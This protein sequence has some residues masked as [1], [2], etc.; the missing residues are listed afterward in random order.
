[1]IEPVEIPSS[2]SANIADASSQPTS[3]R[4]TVNNHEDGW[5]WPVIGLITRA[6][7]IS[8]ILF[9]FICVHSRFSL[10]PQHDSPP[11]EFGV[12]EINQQA[13]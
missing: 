2:E 12:L 7:P 5:N 3:K 4:I 10:F 9:A 13:N 6:R 11:F 1:M 8:T